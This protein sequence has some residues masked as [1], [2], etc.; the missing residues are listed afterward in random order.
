MFDGTIAGNVKINEK[1]VTSANDP[2]SS[3]ELLSRMRSRN[4]ALLNA[5]G[6]GDKNPSDLRPEEL[7]L[8]T[9]IR[10]HI[11][12]GCA[13]DGQAATTEILDQFKSRIPAQ[14]SAQFKAMLSQL[15]DFHKIH[16]QGTWILKPEFR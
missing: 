15:C 2:L 11:A 7:E 13:V 12:F 3:S 14:N 1:N 9:D 10:N 5:G 6:E 8:F 4:H 16:G